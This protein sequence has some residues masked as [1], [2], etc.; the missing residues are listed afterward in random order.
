LLPPTTLPDPVGAGTLDLHC[1]LPSTRFAVKF[2]APRLVKDWTSP[3]TWLERSDAVRPCFSW[4][5]PPIVEA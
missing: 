1:R 3:L 2:W 5:L 4:T